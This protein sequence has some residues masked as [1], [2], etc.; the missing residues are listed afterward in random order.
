[1]KCDEARELWHEELDG[2][3][4]AGRREAVYQHISECDACRALV[5]ATEAMWLLPESVDVPALP[6]DF[7]GLVMAEVRRRRPVAHGPAPWARVL[8]GSAGAYIVAGALLY[9]AIVSVVPSIGGA[10]PDAVRWLHSAT[11]ELLRSAAPWI[12]DAYVYIPLGSVV[13]ACM[14]ALSGVL[15]WCLQSQP[16]LARSHARGMRGHLPS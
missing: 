3:P 13:V 5:E 7:T 11:K 12:A 15:A 6:A 16:A 1:M 8:L 9:V 14:V 4:P 2:E 10:L